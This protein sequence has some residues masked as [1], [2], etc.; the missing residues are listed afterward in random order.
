MAKLTTEEHRER[1][2]LLHKVLDEVVADF[3]RHNANAHMTN[4][5]IMQLMEWSH[6]QTITPDVETTP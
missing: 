3:L 5:T 2:R 6:Q 1:H 4:T